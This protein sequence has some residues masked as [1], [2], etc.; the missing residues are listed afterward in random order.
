MN[1]PGIFR[2]RCAVFLFIASA[3][4]GMCEP[5]ANAVRSEAKTPVIIVP[6]RVHLVQ[7]KATPAMHTTMT[8]A[9]VRRIFGKVNMVWSQ[10]DISF[11]IESIVRTEAAAVSPELDAKEEFTRVI[12]MIPK[13]SLCTTAL[14]VC[15]VKEV[16][17]NGF[18]HRG[19]IVVKETAS[20]QTVEGG[21]DEP[22][23]R[24][25]SHEIGHALRLAHRQDRTNLMAS[26][27]TGFSLNDAEIKAAR[28]IAAK[29]QKP[30]SSGAAQTDSTPIS[31]ISFNHSNPE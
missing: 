25:T 20:L 14:N 30:T 8:E 29:F 10:A 26:G 6:V 28:E 13:A 5:V 15:Y 16:K 19:L 3:P 17:P 21:I 12:A 7:S 11:E 4:C 31:E 23:P 24:V 18:F 27:T 9:D 2:A 22:L 1:L